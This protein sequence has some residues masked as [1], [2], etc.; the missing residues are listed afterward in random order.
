MKTCDYCGRENADDTAHCRE[1]GTQF[2]SEDDPRFFQSPERVAA[3]KKIV[4]GA[5]S[6]SIGVLA[7]LVAW[8]YLEP[9]FGIG[10]FA[11]ACGATLFGGLRICRG[12]ADREKQRGAEKTGIEALSYAM[13]LEAEGRVQEALVVYQQIVQEYPDSNLGRDAKKSIRNLS[14]KLGTGAQQ[15]RQI[16][17]NATG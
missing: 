4:T 1:C 7:A 13:N 11:I 17:G 2:V 3:V 14:Q 8:F 10:F 12:L 9:G 6:C 16:S 15:R 5:M